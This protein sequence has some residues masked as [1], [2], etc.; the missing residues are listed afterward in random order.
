MLQEQIFEEIKQIPDEKLPEIYDLIHYFRVG[1][2]HEAQAP[3]KPS[4][5]SFSERCQGQ[6]K[7]SNTTDDARLDYLKQRYQL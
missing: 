4:T 5:L 6:F 2:M 1:L 3:R 7:L